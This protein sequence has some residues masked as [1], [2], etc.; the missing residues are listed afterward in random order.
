MLQNS[1]CHKNP[2]I[3]DN[4]WENFDFLTAGETPI[5]VGEPFNCRS[6]EVQ[7]EG[8]KKR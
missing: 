6:K 5:A 3:A 7:S 2:D 4:A 8:Q 1:P